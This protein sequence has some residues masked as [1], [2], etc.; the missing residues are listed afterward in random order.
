MATRLLVLI[1]GASITLG[2]G[3]IYDA[4][5][6]PA[7]T[8]I[9]E[10]AIFGQWEKKRV[11]GPKGATRDWRAAFGVGWDRR[12]AHNKCGQSP[13]VPTKSADAPKIG[14]SQA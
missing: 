11:R 14:H 5:S 13:C 4:V 12:T 6:A 8:K 1:M 2:A 7:V 3:Y 9:I 10:L